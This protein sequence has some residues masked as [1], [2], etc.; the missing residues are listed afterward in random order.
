MKNILLLLAIFFASHCRS[1]TLYVSSENLPVSFATVL[2]SQ[3]GIVGYTDENGYFN[4]KIKPTSLTVS[5]IGYIST[6]QYV[7]TG[8][9]DT[10]KIELNKNIE[11][12]KPVKINTVII[13]KKK[14][15]GFGNLEVKTSSSI[16]LRQHIIMAVMLKNPPGENDR[17]NYLKA[18]TF[19]LD[20]VSQLK[21]NSFIME[22]KLFALTDDGCIDSIPLNMKP[23]YFYTDKAKVINELL[24]AELIEIPEGGL[25]VSIVLPSILDKH[26][27][28]T[29]TFVGNY[30][31]QK[32]S[33]F[34]KRNHDDEWYCSDLLTPLTLKSAGFWEMNF[35]IIY[36]KSKKIKK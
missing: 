12:L 24:I 33:T 32:P 16:T 27:D 18:I 31:S 2:D 10:L 3:I 20:K 9:L 19:K 23:I 28:W 34:V 35:G 13:N 36:W 25:V 8:I 14:S 29:I 21:K 22:M 30:K 15:F 7:S 5:H 4:F 17:K 6:K 1:Q 26:N 11:T